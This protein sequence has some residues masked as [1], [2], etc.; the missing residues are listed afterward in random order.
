MSYVVYLFTFANEEFTTGSEQNCS[1]FAFNM[2]ENVSHYSSLWENMEAE[3]VIV[4]SEAVNIFVFIRVEFLWWC[5]ILIFKDLSR[6]V[7]VLLNLILNLDPA[8][9]QANVGSDEGNGFI[10]PPNNSH[11]MIII[12]TNNLSI[13]L[14]L[15]VHR[16]KSSLLLCD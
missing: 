4:S 3:V 9:A 14:Y 11:Y 6:L 15:S 1:V 10:N 16:R 8:D 7:V 2:L 12:L 13:I 5:N